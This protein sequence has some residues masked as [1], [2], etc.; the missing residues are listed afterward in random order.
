MQ[1]S[2]SKCYLLPR[3]GGLAS[4]FYNF[5]AFYLATAAAVFLSFPKA[6]V[7]VG[8]LMPATRSF[9][10][11]PGPKQHSAILGTIL[12]FVSAMALVYVPKT[13]AIKDEPLLP[14]S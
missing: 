9:T 11:L 3:S 7:V 4:H 14:A 8:D 12:I 5:S 1:F 13:I 6:D 2:Y 10:Y